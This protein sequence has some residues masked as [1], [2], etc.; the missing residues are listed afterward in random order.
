[1]SM[2][3]QDISPAHQSEK[4]SLIV[5]KQQC[6][7]E[8]LNHLSLQLECWPPNTTETIQIL[9]V[10]FLSYENSVLIISPH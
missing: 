1:M 9:C 4:S 7:K 5:R 6:I 3:F 10:Y 2:K 8:K